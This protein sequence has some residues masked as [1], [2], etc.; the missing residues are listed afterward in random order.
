M[1]YW[2]GGWAGWI[3]MSVA[4]VVFWGLILWVVVFVVRAFT[5]PRSEQTPPGSSAKRILDERFARGE[6]DQQEFEERRGVLTR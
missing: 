1:M 3:L 5:V 6:I 4:M 2:D